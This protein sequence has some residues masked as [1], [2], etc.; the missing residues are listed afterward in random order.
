MGMSPGGSL[1]RSD[2]ENITAI[3]ASTDNLP[4]DPADDSDVDTGIAGVSGQVT[5]LQSSVTQI[6]YDTM[7]SAR[8]VGETWYVDGNGGSDANTGSHP[9]DAF[10][11]IGAAV[12]AASSGD[13]I[14][15][16]AGVY[17]ETAT[18]N[19]TNLHVRFSIGSV[20]RPAT[21]N[22]LVISANY[23]SVGSDYGFLVVDPAEPNSTA[24]LVSGN[25]CYLEEIR[26]KCDGEVAIG[27]DVTGSGCDLR[28]CRCANPLTA[29]FKDQGDSNRFWDCCT[30]G[31]AGSSSIGF[32][33]TNSCDKA[34]LKGCGS[35][36]N[37]GAGFQVD[38]GCT[39]GVIEDCYSGGGDG[40]HT[41]ADNSFVWSRFSYE[42]YKFAYSTFNGGTQYNIFRI[43]GAVR[44]FNIYGHV[45]RKISAD[46]VAINLELYSANAAVDITDAAGAPSVTGRV[47]GTVFARLEPATEPLV[48]GEP[49]GTPAVLESANYRD[50]HVP[51][52]LIEDDSAA[53]YVQVVVA[54]EVASGQIHWHIEW[55]P[56][57]G[58]G[59][60]E[61]L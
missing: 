45:T 34:R 25:F 23:C 33:M 17:T 9:D 49:D 51:I 19:K 55:E 32:W 43:Y 36:G 7:R 57:T 50:P 28:R 52:V 15:V 11:T 2:I 1:R 61:G 22:G 40:K 31:A 44:V 16:G 8:S 26:A 37:G 35:Q 6:G 4:A 48:V 29:A 18:L 14:V 12:T 38:T 58:D 21:G 56:V 24:V 53:T 10:A 20:L 3:R 42:R 41:D 5:N 13:L 47:V 60:V 27:F 46:D 59:F 54:G 30:G 39:N